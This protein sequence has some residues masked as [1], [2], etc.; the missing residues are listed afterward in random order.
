[1]KDTTISVSKELH[2]WLTSHGR[3]GER[4]EDVI[5]RMLR[6]EFLKSIQQSTTKKVKNSIKV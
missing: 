4:Y 3:K 2:D 5:R 6:P 1:M